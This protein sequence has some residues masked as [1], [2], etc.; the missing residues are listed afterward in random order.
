LRRKPLRGSE[1]LKRLARRS[2]LKKRQRER[3]LQRRRL[4]ER[5]RKRLRERQMKKPH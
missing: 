2:W 3:D 1:S 4:K 5:D